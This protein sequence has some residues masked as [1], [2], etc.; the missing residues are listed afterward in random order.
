MTDNQKTFIEIAK[1]ECKKIGVVY[2][3]YIEKQFLLR[4]NYYEYLRVT[5][6]FEKLS[7]ILNDGSRD[8]FIKS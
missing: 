8:V 6:Q 5:R 2:S 7:L 4:F 1:E 3:D